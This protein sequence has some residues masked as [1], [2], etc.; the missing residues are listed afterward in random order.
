MELRLPQAMSVG[1]MRSRLTEAG[2]GESTIQVFGDP[3]DVLIRTQVAKVDAVELG[4]RV[5]DALGRDGTGRAEIRRVE[6]V[7]PQIG[8]ELRRQA[9]YAVLA[10]LG[11][12]LV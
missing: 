7:G 4:R 9:L 2:L 8:Q 5:G 6:F 12:I 1:A 10:A 11:G 3:R